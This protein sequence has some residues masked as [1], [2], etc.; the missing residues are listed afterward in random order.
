MYN[1]APLDTR[2]PGF[3][4]TTT[5]RQGGETPSPIRA[6]ST[7][8]S[9]DVGKILAFAVA[10]RVL[11]DDGKEWEWDGH[12]RKFPRGFLSGMCVLILEYSGRNDVPLVD[13]DAPS[14]FSTGITNSQL[15]YHQPEHSSPPHPR[16]RSNAITYAVIRH[17]CDSA[18]LPAD[19]ADT[20][21]F[22]T[23]EDAERASSAD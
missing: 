1:P 8:S 18:S 2:F 3:F 19:P 4:T 10:E 15:R 12:L 13:E 9:M 6:S 20:T 5:T 14:P 17:A 7:T 23:Y 22:G 11:D 21:A 16:I